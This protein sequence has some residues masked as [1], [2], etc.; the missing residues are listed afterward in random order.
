M[1]RL[2]SAVIVC[3]LIG[4]YQLVTAQVV[5][6][7]QGRLTDGRVTRWFDR[8]VLD[9]EGQGWRETKAHS[10]KINDLRSPTLV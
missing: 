2:A 9:I 1:R 7:S 3:L 4:S 5:D 10:P 6:P 8:R